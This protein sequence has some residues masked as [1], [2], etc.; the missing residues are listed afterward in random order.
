MIPIK[1]PKK[2]GK[3]VEIPQ[4]CGFLTWSIQNFVKKVKQFTGKYCITL[5]IT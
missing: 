3:M 2:I 1:K 5:L 4:E